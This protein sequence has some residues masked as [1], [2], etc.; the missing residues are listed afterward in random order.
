MG[1]T[2]VLAWMPERVSRTTT[3]LVRLRGSPISVRTMP[4][5]RCMGAGG[6][7]S[8][9]KFPRAKAMAATAAALRG[10]D[11][12][13]EKG[14]R[15][16]PMRARAHRRARGKPHAAAEAGRAAEGGCWGAAAAAAGVACGGC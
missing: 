13:W 8:K 4:T 11:G 5:T 7:A 15:P 14:W 12:P 3:A 6:K 2:L 1:V 9:G 10:L 16:R